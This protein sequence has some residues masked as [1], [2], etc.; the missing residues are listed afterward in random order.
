[1]A[2]FLASSKAWNMLMAI[3][4]CRSSTLRLI[5]HDVHD[6]KNLRLAVIRDFLL[7]EIGKQPRHARIL[8]HQRMNEIGMQQR[9]DLTLGQHALDRAVVGQ[10]HDFQARRPGELKGFVKFADPF[11]GF[12]RHAVFMLQ[13]A[14]H[15][16][17]RGRLELLEPDPAAGEIG[18][19]ADALLR[20]DEDEAV[21]KAAVQE[22]R[23]RVER[24]ALI[25]RDQIRRARHLRDIKFLVAQEAPM[26]RRR[27]HLGQ[28]VQ[29]DAIRPDLF[30]R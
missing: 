12:E 11:D 21:T 30:D 28:H 27:V 29:V 14:A 8:F 20:V 1:M 9:I 6:R 23:K 24:Q 4:G 16:D 7:A 3:H 22:N 26:A 17:D 15:P 5:A 19:A 25:A 2:A 18:R 13:D 10:A